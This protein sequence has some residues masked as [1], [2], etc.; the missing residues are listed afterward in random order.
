MTLVLLITVI[1]CTFQVQSA[2]KSLETTGGASLTS[3]PQPLAKLCSANSADACPRASSWFCKEGQCECG[4]YPQN[5][6][7]CNGTRS[8]VLRQYCATFDDSL[9]ITLAGHCN[10]I[11][12]K[13]TRY[14]ELQPELFHLLPLSIRQLNDR[15][16]KYYN[17]TGVLCGRC[18]PDH[19]PLAYSFNMTCIPCPRAHWNWFRYIMAAYVPLTLFYLVVLFSKINITSSHLFAVVYYC[20]A[21]SLPL[22]LRSLF[23]TIVHQA[24]PSYLVAAKSLFAVYGIWNL[25]FFRPFY[26]DLCLGI[27]VLPTLALDYVI[28][29][30]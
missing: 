5:I 22:V 20:Q 18:L 25:D 7:R 29:V 28:A 16:C 9:N 10:F 21:L 11:G 1:L 2:A 4:K 13:A 23:P 12:N 15:M 30:W 26:S 27:G 19:Y 17:R 24:K 14:Q 8:F 6:I 3:P